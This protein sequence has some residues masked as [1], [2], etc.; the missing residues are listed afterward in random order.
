VDRPYPNRRAGCLTSLGHDL[1]STTYDD[2]LGFSYNPAS[3]IKQNTRSNDTY[4]WNGHYNVTRA[5]TS[6]GLNQY[7]ASGSA[8]LSY[9]ANGNLTS[10]GSTSYVYDDEEELCS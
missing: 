4:A 9:D 6:N 7:T 5:Y 2:S 3:Q 10:D 8:S 1:A